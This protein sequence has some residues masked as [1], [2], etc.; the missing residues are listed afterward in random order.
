MTLRFPLCVYKTCGCQAKHRVP[1]KSHR[2]ASFESDLISVWRAVMRVYARRRVEQI[3]GEP[4]APFHTWCYCHPVCF[5]FQQTSNATQS[6]QLLKRKKKITQRLFLYTAVW[7]WPLF[8]KPSICQNTQHTFSKPCA[9]TPKARSNKHSAPQ[10]ESERKTMEKEKKGH[11]RII[12]ASPHIIRQYVV[13][14][15]IAVLL[16]QAARLRH[17]SH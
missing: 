7:H 15:W 3:P 6:I 16:V 17:V 12:Q 14:N 10:S 8:C 4:S 9:L 1:R 5:W 2:L 13:I 11:I